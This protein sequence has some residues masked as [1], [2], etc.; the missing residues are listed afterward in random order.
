MSQLI[1]NETPTW[2]IDWVNKVFTFLNEIDY[3]TTLTMDGAEYTD[4]VVDTSDRR[5]VT[6]TDAPI[7][8]IYADYYVYNAPAEVDTECTFWSVKS[9][10]WDLLWQK[11]T[12]TNF[13]DTIVWDEIN[14]RA[15]EI[16][17]GKVV[18]KLNPAQTFRAWSLYFRDKSLSVRIKSWWILTEEFNIWDT[19]ASTDTAN[20]LTSWYVEI[21]GDIVKYT[22]KSSTQL[23]WT[24]WQTIDHL[25]S[26]N[27]IQLYEMPS[28]MDK[29]E[30]VELITIWQEARPQ[31]IE[32]DNTWT[33]R[34]YYQIIR[35]D[36]NVILLKIVWLD[37]DDLVKISY[38]KKYVNMTSNTDTCPFPDQY[39][40]TVLAYIVAWSLWY[41]KGIPNSQQHL[42]S[43]YTSLE[44]MYWDFNDEV[45]VIK[46]KI[47]PQGYKFNSIN[48]R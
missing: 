15:I 17:K 48:R 42:N 2:N 29:P 1:P 8:A 30:K 9:K 18:N 43:G 35:T 16:W 45:N 20:L 7:V 23:T 28:N 24:S 40:I 6:L 34:V 5:I 41:D 44:V 27:V 19:E 14:N 26:E 4:F 25:E 37:A 11:S 12:S 33:N 10:V 22:W 31:E 13:S 46:Q 32:L 3:I 47:R 38:P 21:W 36:D 39:W